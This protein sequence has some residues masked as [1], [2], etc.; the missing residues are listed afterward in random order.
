MIEKLT[1]KMQKEKEHDSW[2]LITLLISS[3]NRSVLNFKSYALCKYLH[4]WLNVVV[5]FYYLT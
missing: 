4:I 5:E 3:R 2:I 1:K